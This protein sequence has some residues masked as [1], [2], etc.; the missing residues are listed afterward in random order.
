MIIY[1]TSLFTKYGETSIP[2]QVIFHIRKITN[3]DF[4]STKFSPNFSFEKVGRIMI[5]KNQI[6]KSRECSLIRISLILDHSY[7][8]GLKTLHKCQA[9]QDLAH[10]KISTTQKTSYFYVSSVM[11]IWINFI[12]LGFHIKRT[13]KY[14]L[15]T[16]MSS[17]MAPYLYFSKGCSPRW[18]CLNTCYNKWVEGFSDK[19]I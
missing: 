7:L 4:N 10:L 1:M 16:R 11:M 6:G 14:A 9:K 3:G 2:I 12:P 17:I 15:I 18:K 13:K 5:R 19:L 8:W